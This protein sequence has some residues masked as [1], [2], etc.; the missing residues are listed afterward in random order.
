MDNFAYDVIIHV[1]ILCHLALRYGNQEST[2][3][4]F[5]S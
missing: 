1:I 5:C 4:G 2:N 3:A